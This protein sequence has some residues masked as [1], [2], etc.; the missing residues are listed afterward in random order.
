MTSSSAMPRR[1]RLVEVGPRDGF[2]M[3][4]RFLPTELKIATIERLVGAGVREIEATSFVH[5]GVVPQMADAENV[6]A[7][8]ERR[9]GVAYLALVPNL[10]GAERALAAG[11]DGLRQVIVV[12]ERYNQR[13]VGLSVDESVR[14]FGEVARRSE[15][16]GLEANA[17]LGAAFGCPLEGEVPLARVVEVA[18]R[19]V[20]LGSRQIGLADSAGLGNPLQV[21]R[22][23]T[24]VREALPD[25]PLWLHLH[26]TRGLGLANAL[27]GL[28][29]GIDRFDTALGG[30]GGCPV[31]AGA[32]G[33]IA[34]E[35]MI[36]LCQEMGLST[37]L[38]LSGIREAS[39]AVESFLERELPS[40]VLRAGTRD[41][42]VAL[43]AVPAS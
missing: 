2:Q 28:E 41:E 4:S 9:P 40:R 43:N 7:G 19:C 42:L 5:P 10:R 11:V 25:V 22:L 27:A 16:D 38:D 34:T 39:R 20:E 6:L 33:N 36:Y 35:E 8:L 17:V 1:V 21:R 15:A 13:N 32:S 24:E 3:E 29:M 23:V 31:I 18:R 12:T 37:D 26:D 30:L 14:I